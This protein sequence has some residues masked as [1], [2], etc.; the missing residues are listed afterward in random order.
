M[1]R[2]IDADWEDEIVKRASPAIEPVQQGFTR[3][4]QEFELQGPL[5]FFA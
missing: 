2:L 3:L 5:G 1:A 4:G